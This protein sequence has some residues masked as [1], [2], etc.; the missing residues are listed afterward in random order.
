M[1]L[2]TMI[3]YIFNGEEMNKFNNFYDLITEMQQITHDKE[4]CELLH[5]IAIN[6]DEL[7]TYIE[8]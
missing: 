8:D 7:A 5:N 6:L 3:T 1:K 4:L 2:Q